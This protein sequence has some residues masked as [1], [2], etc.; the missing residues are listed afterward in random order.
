MCA[1]L[2]RLV[3]ATEGCV[4]TELIVAASQLCTHAMPPNCATAIGSVCASAQSTVVH[5]AEHVH[6]THGQLCT[7][8][9]SLHAGQQQQWM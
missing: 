2:P 9:V 8:G 3:A 5:G 4:S 1:T 7:A 6:A